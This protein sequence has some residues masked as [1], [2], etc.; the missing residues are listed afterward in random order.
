MKYATLAAATLGLF[1][2]TPAMHAIADDQTPPAPMDHQSPGHGGWDEAKL[3]AKLGLTDDQAAKLKALRDSGKGAFKPFM[4]KERGLM[5]KLND[6]VVNKAPDT[7]IQTTLKDLKTNR[8]AMKDQM[9]KMEDQKNAILTPT[10]QAKMMLGRRKMM[11]GK[12][13]AMRKGQGPEHPM[14]DAQGPDDSQH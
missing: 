4:E 13:G 10:Q 2:C 7:E 12:R 14:D 5:A 3:K 9:E 11:Q 8:D 1:L 6:Q